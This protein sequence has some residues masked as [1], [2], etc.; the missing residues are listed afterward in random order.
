MKIKLK[1]KP[2]PIFRS[3]CG[4]DVSDWEKLNAKEEIEIKEIPEALKDYVVEIKPKKE[5]K[6]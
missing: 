2:I 3:Y 6:E 5:V 4:L 1:N